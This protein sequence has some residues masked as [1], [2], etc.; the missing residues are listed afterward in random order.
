MFWSLK[1]CPGAGIKNYATTPLNNQLNNP[2][3]STNS[4]NTV[5][6]VAEVSLLENYMREILLLITKIKG[7]KQTL[8]PINLDNRYG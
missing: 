5:S 4:Q 7:E 6:S 2:L 3:I 8:Q 1:T